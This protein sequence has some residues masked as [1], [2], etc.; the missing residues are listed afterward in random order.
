MPK[1]GR[2][3]FSTKVALITIIDEEFE[4]TQELFGLKQKLGVP[5]YFA[6]A[7]APD[8]HY[9][10]VLLRASDR[11]NHAAEEAMIDF[12]E[13]F[14]PSYFVVIGIAGG[15]IGRNDVKLGD[16]VIADFIEYYEMM[17]IE[18]GKFISRKTPHD[19]PSLHMRAKIAEPLRWLDGWRA[20]IKTARPDDGVPKVKVGHIAAGEKLLDDPGHQY[21]R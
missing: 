11:G 13:D 4:I 20:H 6:K 3:G 14:Y 9:D 10:I 8:R 1:A 18:G 16:V 15:A 17:K 12:V 7:E 5:G 2:Q 19:H 21:Q